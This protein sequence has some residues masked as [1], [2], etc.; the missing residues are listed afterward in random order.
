MGIHEQVFRQPVLDI[1][2]NEKG[3]ANTPYCTGVLYTCDV[4]YMFVVPFVDVDKGRYMKDVELARHWAMMKRYNYYAQVWYPQASSEFWKGNTWVNWVMKPGEYKILPSSDP[5]FGED[6]IR[7]YKQEEKTFPDVKALGLKVAGIHDAEFNVLT[8]RY[9]ALEEMNKCSINLL[10]NSLAVSEDWMS[11]ML[12]FQILVSDTNNQERF[13]EVHFTGKIEAELPL[14]NNI[15]VEEVEKEGKDGEEPER[16]YNITIDY[17]LMQA[18]DVLLMTAAERV[19]APL[20]QGTSFEHCTMTKLLE[21][22]CVRLMEKRDVD[23]LA[24][25]EK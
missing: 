10:V 18:I 6:D 25:R 19:I 14:S 17:H 7:M 2:I 24:L 8:E 23:L 11:A 3:L 20:R 13:Y 1:Y 9:V 22:D 4:V 16:G 21:F 12:Y 15:D 5:V